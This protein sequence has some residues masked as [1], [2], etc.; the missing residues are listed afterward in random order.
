[1][2]RHFLFRIP[3][4]DLMQQFSKFEIC[5]L[6]P[7]TMVSSDG[8]FAR[9]HLVTWKANIFSGSWTKGVSAGGCRN[10]QSMFRAYRVDT[11][12]LGLKKN[13]RSVGCAAYDA[14]RGL[15]CVAVQVF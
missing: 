6:G 5:N 2:I 13:E 9:K 11:W 7:E 10:F 3:Y 12:L 4:A 8:S 15:R 14:F 1:M